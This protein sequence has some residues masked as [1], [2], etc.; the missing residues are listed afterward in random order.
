MLV[1]VAEE[2]TDPAILPILAFTVVSI[3]PD[4]EDAHEM[5]RKLS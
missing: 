5:I 2:T 4:N 1:S 3:F